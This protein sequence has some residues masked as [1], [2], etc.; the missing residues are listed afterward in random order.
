M[1]LRSYSEYRAG[2]MMKAQ[3]GFLIMSASIVRVVVGELVVSF[4]GHSLNY[5]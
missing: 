5:I 4:N 2:C 1:L 3:A